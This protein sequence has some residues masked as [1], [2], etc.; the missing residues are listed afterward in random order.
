MWVHVG[1]VCLCLCV[2]TCVCLS[3]CL[4]VL[5]YGVRALCVHTSTYN[6]QYLCFAHRVVRDPVSGRLTVDVRA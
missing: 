2:S 4:S 3:M 1:Y 6:R 5:M